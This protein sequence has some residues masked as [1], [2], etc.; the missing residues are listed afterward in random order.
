[1]PF[2][3]DVA[4]CLLGISAA[5]GT[6]SLDAQ[7]GQVHPSPSTNHVQLLL[8]FKHVR[9]LQNPVFKTCRVFVE[10]PECFQGQQQQRSG[11]AAATGFGV[12]VTL[13]GLDGRPGHPEALPTTRMAS[14]QAFGSPTRD[15]HE[16]PSG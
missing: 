6:L 4:L 5:F 16:F 11:G 10:Q 15:S 8:H 9:V 14:P 13:A 1:M 12:L 7:G 3:G 2:F